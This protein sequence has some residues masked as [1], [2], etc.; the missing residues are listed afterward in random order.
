MAAGK[1]SDAPHSLFYMCCRAHN[2]IGRIGRSSFSQWKEQFR[3]KIAVRRSAQNP[4][5]VK[6]HA[7]P[8]AADK[9]R[10]YEAMVD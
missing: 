5:T 7:R 8:P 6:P 3:V 9:R 10:D 2:A 1:F 4:A